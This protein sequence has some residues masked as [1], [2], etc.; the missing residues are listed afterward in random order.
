MFKTNKLPKDIVTQGRKLSYD[1]D[2][3]RR[4]YIKF[5]ILS[6]EYARDFYDGNSYKDR[7]EAYKHYKRNHLKAEWYKRKLDIKGYYVLPLNE[8]DRI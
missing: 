8:Y 7:M 1:N 5:R 6:L 2:Y 3:L 4:R